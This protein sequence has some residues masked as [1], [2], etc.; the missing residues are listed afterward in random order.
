MKASDRHIPVLLDEFLACFADDKMRIFVDATL[1]M[2][3]HAEAILHSHPEIEL[4]IGIDQD[5]EALSLAKERLGP[6]KEKLRLIHANFAELD[7]VL[8]R[9]KI[10]FIDGIF[11]D[12]GVS[13]LQLDEASR[14]FSFLREGPLDMRMDA[15]GSVTA[16]DI[17]NEW[18]E[19]DLEA[20]FRSYGEIWRAKLLA[21]VI[22]QKRSI[23][24]FKT[25]EDLSKVLTSYMPRKGKKHP[26]TQVFQALRIAV[27]DELGVLQKVI[28]IGIEKLASRGKMGVIAFHS[29]EDRIVKNLFR[30]YAGKGSIEHAVSPGGGEAAKLKVPVVEI[31]TKKPLVAGSKEVKDNPR[32]RSAKMRF[33][34]KL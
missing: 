5:K 24:K 30:Y 1:G 6:F 29:L 16:A 9:E 2:G 7:E 3:G 18:P 17:V 31:I 27:N 14:G 26:M 10:D 25:T 23:K 13:S 11:F 20:I 21:Q 19:R 33:I 32:S 12:V 34:R 4:F 15:S 22:V 8:Q 28:P